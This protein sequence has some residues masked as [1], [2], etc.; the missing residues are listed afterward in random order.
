MNPATVAEFWTTRVPTKD[1]YYWVANHWG[2]VIG[3]CNLITVAAEG[4][5]PAR[6]YRSY[7]M[8]HAHSENDYIRDEEVALWSV[9]Q[10]VV[11]KNISARDLRRLL[12]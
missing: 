11:P 8:L 5:V 9:E 4:V 6:T 3:L 2:D 1:G 7:V 12:P 10:A